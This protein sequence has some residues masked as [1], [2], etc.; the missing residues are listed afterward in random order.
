MAIHG[1]SCS[2]IGVDAGGA[3]VTP[4]TRSFTPDRA[5]EAACTEFFAKYAPKVSLAGSGLGFGSYR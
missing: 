3:A 4:E 5:T 1:N 2:K